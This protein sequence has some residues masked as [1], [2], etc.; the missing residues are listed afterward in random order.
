MV[1]DVLG[2]FVERLPSPVDGPAAA[3][4]DVDPAALLTPEEIAAFRQPS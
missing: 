3:L 1:E 2:A 4:A